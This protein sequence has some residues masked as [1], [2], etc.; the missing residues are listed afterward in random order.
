MDNFYPAGLAPSGY[1]SQAGPTAMA[2]LAYTR[3]AQGPILGASLP[4]AAQQLPEDDMELMEL[5]G[6]FREC[7][8]H[9]TSVLRPPVP[10]TA[11]SQPSTTG[12]FPSMDAAQQGEANASAT[13]EQ[14]ADAMVGQLQCCSSVDEARPKCAEMLIAF[15]QRSAQSSVDATRLRTLQGANS[16]LLRGFRNLY[17]RQREA[18]ARQQQAEEE[19]RQMAAELA[20][21]REALQTSERAKSALQYHLQLM[22]STQGDAHS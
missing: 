22:G 19:N 4:E 15:Q 11:S 14:W 8:L 3:P 12:S 21:C 1:P 7:H 6:L 18:A 5:L 2:E 17:H 9:D 10:S 20:R 16:A 13:L